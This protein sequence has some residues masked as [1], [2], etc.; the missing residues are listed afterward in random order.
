[1]ISATALAV[2]AELASP[3][4]E[5]EEG[6]ACAVKAR[7]RVGR[8]CSANS[9]TDGD[10]ARTRADDGRGG[11]AAEAAATLAEAGNCKW[12]RI[13]KEH[14]CASWAPYAPSHQPCDQ[15]PTLI[16]A[17]HYLLHQKKRQNAPEVQ[18]LSD[19]TLHPLHKQSRR[20]R[21]RR[22]FHSTV[23]QWRP[24]GECAASARK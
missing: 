1:M 19:A 3:P 24:G 11:N 20:G 5:W 21:Q 13:S 8:E 18:Q 17:C 7:A 15:Q 23:L 12:G 9:R 10:G 2:A 4:M 6:R 14:A 22:C 16:P